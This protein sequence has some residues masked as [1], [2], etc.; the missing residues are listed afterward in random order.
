MIHYEFTSE[1]INCVGRY[2]IGIASIISSDLKYAESL[3]LS[4]L[5]NSSLRNCPIPSIRKIYERT[6][7]HLGKIYYYRGRIAFENWKKTKNN[8]FLSEIE[9]NLSQL[10]HVEPHNY[11]GHLLRA[12]YYFISDRNIEDS[13]SELKKC[14]NYNNPVWKF[15]LAFLIAYSGDLKGAIRKYNSIFNTN[16]DP[17]TI[18]EI[19]EFIQIILDE[20]PDKIQLYFCLGYL[21]Y[22]FKNDFSLAI[23]DFTSFI[24]SEV[25]ERYSEELILA[26]QYIFDSYSRQNK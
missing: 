11:E 24:N 1:L 12:I 7:K 2:I 20:E 26:E 13:I 14:R 8:S 5:N 19:E 16:W 10:S 6:P 25:P 18:T 9:T 22:K 23:K 21:N 17:Q 15:N 4:I 3:F